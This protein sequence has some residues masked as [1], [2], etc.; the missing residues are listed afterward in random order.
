LERCDPTVLDPLSAN[1]IERAGTVQFQFKDE[2]EAF[3][4]RSEIGI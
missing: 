1:K 4:D 2:V 3:D